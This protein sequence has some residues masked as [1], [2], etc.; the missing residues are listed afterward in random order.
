M[1]LAFIGLGGNIGDVK[2][3]IKDAIVCLAQRP[4]LKVITR[5][6]MYKSAP[7][8]AEGADFI[9]AVISLETKLSP[10]ELL[11][12]CQEI[13]FQFGRERSYKNAPRTLDLDILTYDTISISDH[14]LTIPHPRMTERAFVLLPL[15]EISPHLDLPGLGKI[16]EY[17]KNLSHQRIEKILGCNCPSR[18]V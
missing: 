11:L 16:S 10:Q 12:I 4:E 15:L 9:N 8:D 18:L 13:E 6:C 14:N 5:S 7:V 17:V 2:Q 1:A 3:L